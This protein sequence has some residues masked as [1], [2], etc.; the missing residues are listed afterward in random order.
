M[1]FRIWAMGAEIALN[2]SPHPMARASMGSL[3]KEI[4]EGFSLIDTVGDL[5][6]LEEIQKRCLDSVPVLA[7][8]QPFRQFVNAKEVVVAIKH[9]FPNIDIVTFQLLG[10]IAEASYQIPV[11]LTRDEI[12][13]SLA[14]FLLKI[15]TTT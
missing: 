11:G 4:G 13:Q 2:V 6:S 7:L 9:T 5:A 12:K 3:L 14:E 8:V 1:G 10:R 15:P